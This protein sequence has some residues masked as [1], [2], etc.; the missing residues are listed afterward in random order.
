MGLELSAEESMAAMGIDKGD[1]KILFFDGDFFN[2]GSFT[3]AVHSLWQSDPNNTRIVPV[4]GP[5]RKGTNHDAFFESWAGIPIYLLELTEDMRTEALK[6]VTELVGPDSA[7]RAS[8]RIPDE[9]QRDHTK[10]GWWSILNLPLDAI[11]SLGGGDTTGNEAKMYT[12]YK[13]A[14]AETAIAPKWFVHTLDRA[15]AKPEDQRQK[16]NEFLV[17]FKI[18]MDAEIAKTKEGADSMPVD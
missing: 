13:E 6:Q 11:I 7:S 16:C 5:P 18:D 1:R 14:N 2:M 15:G 3:W 17:T 8:L 9:Q 10:L 4:R 12:A